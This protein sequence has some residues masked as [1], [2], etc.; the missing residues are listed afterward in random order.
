MKIRP[1]YNRS[2]SKF[3]FELRTFALV[4]MSRRQPMQILVKIGSVRISPKV[5]E[6]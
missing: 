2:P 5:S 3:E 6:I 4:I 1:R